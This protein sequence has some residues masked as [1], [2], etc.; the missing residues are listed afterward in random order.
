ALGAGVNAIV[1]AL[2]PASGGGIYAG[3]A[4]Q[5]AG[6]QPAKYVAQ[7]DGRAWSALGGGV[8]AEVYALT[9]GV[10]GL[11]AG[12][13]FQQAGGQPA[14]SAAS[15]APTAASPWPSRRAP[16]L[17][18]RPWPTRACPTRPRRRRPPSSRWPCSVW[19]RPT[20]PAT[21]SL[22]SG[23]ATPCPSPTRTPSSRRG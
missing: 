9:V 2:A 19:R 16:S 15:P 3:G 18:T 23:R 7:W 12:G 11:Y 20:T 13:S 1:F 4:F 17:A 10:A 21:R 6:G 8:D 14:R 22:L 5:Q